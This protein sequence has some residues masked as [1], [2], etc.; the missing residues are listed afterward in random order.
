MRKKCIINNYLILYSLP[1]LART[2]FRYKNRRV[3]SDS[4]IA[5]IMYFLILFIVCAFFNSFDLP[6]S[7]A[8]NWNY[9]DLGPDVW[10]DLYPDCGK[11]KQSPIN[12]KTACTTYNEYSPFQ[13]SPAYAELQDFRITNDGH[14]VTGVQ[15]NPTASPLILSGGGLTENFTFANFHLHWGENYGTG[16]EHQL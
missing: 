10:P 5:I 1:L 13:F 7:S 11:T 3:Y 15:V 12:I 4:S 8:V 2:I 16:S 6:L 14:T 9:E